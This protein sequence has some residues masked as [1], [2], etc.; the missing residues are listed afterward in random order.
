ME[1]ILTADNFVELI[2]S[3]NARDRHK[4]RAEKLIELIL[5]LEVGKIDNNSDVITSME[6]RI[7]ELELKYDIV[8]TD[9]RNNAVDIEN[10]RRDITSERV[11]Q[12]DNDKI[13]AIE[14]EISEIQNHLNA[15]E[16]YLRVNNLE[17]VGLPEA[18]DEA[19]NESVILAAINSLEELTYEITKDH[20]D[21]SHPIPSRRGD[22]KRVY[23]QVY[24][25]EN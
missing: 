3:M 5:T 1:D 2:K 6:K 20:I 10:I 22:G 7:S 15:I 14:K 13:V 4:I 18:Q 25:Q 11:L 16:Q 19:S 12:P 23:M 9:S 17:F 24:K 8:K 21:I